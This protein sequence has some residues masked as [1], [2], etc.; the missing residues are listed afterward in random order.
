MN[1]AYF[2]NR[3]CLSNVNGTSTSSW[4]NSTNSVGLA[5]ASNATTLPVYYLCN[6]LIQ[7][8]KAEMVEVMV[9]T[10]M[11]ALSLLYIS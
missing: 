1:L 3:Y 6:N 8:K 5:I 10:L 9:A 4:Y 2:Q 7:I 11:A